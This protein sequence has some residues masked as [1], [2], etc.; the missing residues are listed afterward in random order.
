MQL[1]QQMKDHSWLNHDKINFHYGKF[2]KDPS[3]SA[4]TVPVIDT[5]SESNTTTAGP[6]MEIASRFKCRPKGTT[7]ASKFY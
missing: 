1:K 3:R 5:G 7:K 2:K 4:V 6:E